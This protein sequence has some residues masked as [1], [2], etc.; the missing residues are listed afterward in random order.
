V[1]VLTC[2]DGSYYTGVTNDLLRRL[3][4]H[5]AGKAS[6]YTRCR[7]PVQL[8]CALGSWPTR[9]PAPRLEARIKAMTRR[10]KQELIRQERAAAE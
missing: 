8:V 1:Y 6:K 2:A 10:E 5:R 3:D 4:T 9:G 7:L